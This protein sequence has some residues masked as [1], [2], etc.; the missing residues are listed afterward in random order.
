MKAA[1]FEQVCILGVGAFSKV[2]HVIN[3]QYKKEYAM[4]QL[5]KSKLI[6]KNCVKDVIKERDLMSKL[7]HPFLVNMYFSF[8]DSNY[9]YM[10]LDLMTGGDL[11]YYNLKKKIFSENECKFL[12]LCLIMGLEYL[13]ANKIIHRD[14]KPENIVIDQFGYFY[15]T[16]FGT[17]INYEKIEEEKKI[18]GSLGYMAPEVILG[19]KYDYEIDY[20]A[21]GAICYEALTGKLPYFAKS[22]KEI[23]ELILANQVQIKTF[24]KPQGWSMESID[25]IN[26]LIQRNPEKRLGKNGIEEIKNHPWLKDTDW[27]KLYLHELISPFSSSVSSEWVIAKKFSDK[28]DD[29]TKATLERCINIEN[30]NDFKHQF[31]EYF[32]FNRYSMK[33]GNGKSFIN[34]HQKYDIKRNIIN[35]DSFVRENNRKKLSCN[36][37][38]NN[39]ARINSGKPNARYSLKDG[40]FPKRKSIFERNGK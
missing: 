4:K 16:D 6:D 9:L 40:K 27:Q 8:Q 12:A 2:W 32:Y 23:K 17:C 22:F 25:F 31:D 35:D 11:R 20:F 34:P 24:E 39:N 3:T 5:S 26:K 28:N 29:T 33:N 18:I 38:I 36:T 19:E 37:I 15:I 10:I 7:N 1:N 14:I 13:H 21:L 30:R